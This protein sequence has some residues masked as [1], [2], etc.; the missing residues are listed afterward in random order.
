M[1]L[2]LTIGI[3]SFWAISSNA[4]WEQVLDDADYW[5]SKVAELNGKIYIAMAAPNPANIIACYDP[6]GNI[7]Q[8]IATPEMTYGFYE[9]IARNGKLY[10]GGGFSNTVQIY[11]PTTGTW[12]ITDPDPQ[13]NTQVDALEVMDDFIYSGGGILGKLEQY[14]P[15]TSSWSQLGTDYIEDIADILVYDNVLYAAKTSPS[16]NPV[17]AFMKFDFQNDVWIAL[18][19]GLD[20]SEISM[21]YPFEGKIYIA[22]SFILNDS[23]GLAVYDPGSGNISSVEGLDDE[24]NAVTSWSGGLAVAGDFHLPYQR[25]AIYY[26]IT[27]TWAQ[28][29]TDY[30]PQIKSLVSYDAYL[31]AGCGLPL[32][33]QFAR[34]SGSTDISEIQ[35][36]SALTY[37]NP[38]IDKITIPLPYTNGPLKITNSLGET[39]FEDRMSAK[40]ITVDVSSWPAGFYHLIIDGSPPQKVVVVR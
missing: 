32:P 11:D 29:T 4:Q 33:F 21:L 31:Y 17:S 30:L 13:S 1:R 16:G 22:G 14:N 8:P 7:W 34:I 15:S 36:Q 5:V 24:V 38:A 28:L 10:A 35:M 40:T 9:L 3:F 26:P 12:T 25:N 18:D 2:Y 19:E 20:L 6:A 39:V 37:P 27:D 23:Q